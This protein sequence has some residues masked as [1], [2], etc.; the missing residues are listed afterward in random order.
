[1]PRSILLY[2][3]ARVIVAYWILIWLVSL[4]TYMFYCIVHMC[5]VHV[6]GFHNLNN[7]ICV[8]CNFM[9]LYYQWN[10][11]IY[12]EKRRKFVLWCFFMNENSQFIYW[13][14]NQISHVFFH[15]IWKNQIMLRP[16]YF[17]IHQIVFNR[18]NW[19]IFY[20]KKK[21]KITFLLIIQNSFCD[22]CD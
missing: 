7:N 19:T 4:S 9:Y 18:E 3:D 21:I 14:Q 22:F 20:E 10:A 8:L 2:D 12:A 11:N 16:T 5:F 1:M 15:R 6:L 13:D 17:K